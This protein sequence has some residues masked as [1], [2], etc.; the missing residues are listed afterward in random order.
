[1]TFALC[2]EHLNCYARYLLCESLLT[3]ANYNKCIWSKL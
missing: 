3:C 1:M 2:A